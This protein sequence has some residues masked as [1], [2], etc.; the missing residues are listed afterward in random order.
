MD[1][2]L[3]LDDFSYFAITNNAAMNSHVHIFHIHGVI[4]ANKFLTVEFGRS[5]SKSICKF[6][7]LVREK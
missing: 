3:N 7:N 6:T 1:D 2:H 5:K 4:S